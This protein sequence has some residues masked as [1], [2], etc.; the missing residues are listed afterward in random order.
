MIR[1]LSIFL[2]NLHFVYQVALEHVQESIRNNKLHGVFV[3]MF[4]CMC[5]SV[6]ICVFCIVHG[7]VSLQ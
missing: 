6:C 3:C 7:G 1:V 5:V 2:N 4:V